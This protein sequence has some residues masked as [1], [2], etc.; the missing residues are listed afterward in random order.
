[1][2]SINKKTKKPNQ[3]ENKVLQSLSKHLCA[4]E[5]TII[6]TKIIHNNI[7]VCVTNNMLQ[8]YI[9]LETMTILVVKIECKRKAM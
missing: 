7:Y 3:K 8:Q 4:N 5:D 6:N 2:E 1:M 9:E